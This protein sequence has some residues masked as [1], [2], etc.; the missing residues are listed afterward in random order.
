MFQ[1]RWSQSLGA[2][3]GDHEYNGTK[4]HTLAW[5]TKDYIDPYSPCVFMGLYDFRDYIALYRHKGKAWI[6]WC[7][8]DLENLLSGFAFNDG[9]L[10]WMSIITAG[11]FTFWIKRQLKKAEHW[12][13][14]KDEYDKLLKFGFES[15]IGP[16]F[17]GNI[18]SYTAERKLYKHSYKPK[19][20]IVLPKGREV[21][22]GL[23]TLVRLAQ[24]L[25]S[26]TFHVYGTDLR[27]DLS[28]VVVHGRVPKEQFNHEITDYQ[29]GLRLNE[30]DGFSEVTAKSVLMGQYPI[31]KLEYPLI[32]NFNDF[33]ELVSLVDSLREMT[34]PNY[35]ARSYYIKALNNFPWNVSYHS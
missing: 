19:V 21:E 30:H 10:K 12:V 29:C 22:Y 32:P 24:V 8:S 23:Y 5:G 15:N 9:K 4:A 25:T 34:Q 1:C 33:S 26:H 18:K 16:S 28:N 20:Y 11:L 6:L 14:D 7:G 31:T 27:I 35:Q 3:D 17:L 2:L 13:E